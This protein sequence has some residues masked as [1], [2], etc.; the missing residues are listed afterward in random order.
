MVEGG[1]RPPLLR[2]SQKQGSEGR[3]EKAFHDLEFA[4]HFKKYE[5]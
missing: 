4:F 5:K 2:P 3:Q 1:S